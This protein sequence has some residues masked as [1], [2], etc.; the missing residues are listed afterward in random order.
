M[1]NTNI[2]NIFA[3]QFWGIFLVVLGHSLPYKEMPVFFQVLFRWIYAFHMPL[4]FCISG[5]LYKYNLPKY[6]IDGSGKFLKK[7][8]R[9]LIVPLL[10]LNI[11]AFPVKLVL[12][13]FTYRN[14]GNNLM[15]NL[16]SFLYLDKI[17]IG[18]LWFIM[19]LFHIFIIFFFLIPKDAI[20][21]HLMLIP[22]F[23]LLNYI[24]SSLPVKYAIYNLLGGGTAISNLLY[25]Y[26]GAFIFDS[27]CK[28]GIG[29]KVFLS[30][31]GYLLILGYVSYFATDTYLTP[32]I[33]IIGIMSSFG[34]ASCVNISRTVFAVIARYSY[35]IYLLSW[36]P[37]VFIRIVLSDKPMVSLPYFI[38]V[39]ISCLFGIIIPVWIAKM[40]QRTKLKILIGM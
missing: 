10:F 38:I 14:M 27:K 9:R 39:V 18:N 12:E 23:L 1:R 37:Q 2:S 25:F 8:I 19:V 30:I 22:I 4:F 40:I 33:S 6:R 21:K 32:F 3:L 31:L 5:Y 20:E 26:L 15:D 28:L 13:S 11:L 34:L 16:I 24:F 35:Q 17:P 29:F 7:K 36:F